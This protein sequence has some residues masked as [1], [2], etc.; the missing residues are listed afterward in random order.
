MI[1]TVLETLVDAGVVEAAG[2]TAL[3]AVVVGD[4]V[5][6]VVVVVGDVVVLV[7]VVVGDV[8]VLVVVVVGDVVDA[9]TPAV[10]EEP[11]AAVV[12]D[13]PTAVV[14]DPPTAVTVAVVL[15][16]P[17]EAAH[18]PVLVS[19][20]PRAHDVHDVAELQLVQFAEHFMH[21]VPP[22]GS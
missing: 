10:V 11:P 19:V 6:L 18:V 4:V 17:V 1:T 16:T 8:V 21:P 13:P 12:E 20:K 22:A 15:D 14:E 2:G 9:A 7:V 5:V 3:V